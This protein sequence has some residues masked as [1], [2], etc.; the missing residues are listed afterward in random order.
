MK[1][2]M[3]IIMMVMTIMVVVCRKTN[4]VENSSRKHQT[5]INDTPRVSL[6]L[7]LGA[8]QVTVHHDDGNVVHISS[9]EY[10]SVLRVVMMMMSFS[11]LKTFSPD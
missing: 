2:M 11:Y 1:M 8:G 3:T 5:S 10:R 7:L 9:F 4:W 6:S